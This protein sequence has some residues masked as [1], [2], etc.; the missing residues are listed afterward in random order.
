MCQTYISE[1][2]RKLV[3]ACWRCD[4]LATPPCHDPVCVSCEV[5]VIC[6][7]VDE[8]L[9]FFGC[10]FGPAPA[11]PQ[12]WCT[13]LVRLGGSFC[14]NTRTVSSPV[15]SRKPFALSHLRPAGEIRMN[16]ILVLR[17]TPS[18]LPEAVV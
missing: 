13:Y 3:V 11:R 4:A 18:L 5:C 1:Q 14:G 17:S 10:S 15:D 9:C 7:I 2:S 6:G 16:I 12:A 8:G